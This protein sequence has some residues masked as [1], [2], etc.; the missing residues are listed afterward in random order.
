MT[1]LVKGLPNTLTFTFRDPTLVFTVAPLWDLVNDDSL[2]IAAGTSTP[3][4]TVLNGW[5]MTVT[6]PT[7]YESLKGR[8]TLTLELYGTDASGNV[9]STER[10]FD[11]I[12]A[13]DSYLPHG[14]IV[15]QGKRS[16]ASII[17]DTDTLD[18]R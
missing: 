6:I 11:L 18:S 2:I 4:G 14:I 1:N 17:I 12:D 16:T 7:T 8:E 9:K 15:R 13:E 3:S 10:Q 5:D